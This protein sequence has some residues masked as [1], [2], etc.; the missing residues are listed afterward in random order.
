MVRFLIDA[1]LPIN[2]PPWSG[3]EFNHVVY[4]NPKLSDSEIWE[5][6]LENKLTIISKDADFSNRV[7]FSEPPPKVIHIKCG[8][9]RLYQ[10]NRFM[11]SNWSQILELIAS[12]KLVNVY[13]NKL[14]A[15]D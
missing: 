2:C 1:N 8:N 3:Y 6:A 14:E 13:I 5:Y 12:H 11:E 15:I 10:F 7:L 9:M 4:L